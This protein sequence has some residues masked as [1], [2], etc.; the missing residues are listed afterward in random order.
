MTAVL[1][2]DQ[3]D[4]IRVTI[5]EAVLDGDFVW[6]KLRPPA[7]FSPGVAQALPHRVA[8]PTLHPHI[9]PAERR[10]LVE[11]CR[12]LLTEHGWSVP[13][14][15][16]AIAAQLHLSVACVKTHIRSLF[17]KFSVGDLPQNRKRAELAHRALQ[18]GHAAH[19]QL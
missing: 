19:D 12:P 8:P 2:A 10:I 5:E 18:S 7:G 3:R 17:T 13:A 11:L 14:G 15:N 6:L 16:T 4:H 1:P 9:T